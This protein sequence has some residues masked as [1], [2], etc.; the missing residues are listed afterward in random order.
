[1]AGVE[2]KKNA[3]RNDAKPEVIERLSV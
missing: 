1:M 3:M 2:G